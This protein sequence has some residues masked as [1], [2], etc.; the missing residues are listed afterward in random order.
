VRIDVSAEALAAGFSNEPAGTHTSRTVMLAELR[1][2]FG[3][4]PSDSG[5]RDYVAAIIDSNALKKRTRATRLKSLRHLRELY[6]L[7]ASV[8]LFGA[9]RALW[10]SDDDSQPLLAF[11]CAL[12]RDPLLRATA[13]LM[14]AS[15]EGAVVS[16]AD[17]SDEVGRSFPHRFST[18]VL[19]RIGRNVASSWT[20]SGHLEGRSTKVRTRV[21]ATAYSMTYAL[22]L[23]HLTQHS[24]TGLFR[25][26][27]VRLLEVPE[28][29]A[30][31]LARAASRQGWIGYRSAAGM[32]EIT[33]REL[34]ASS[35][36]KRAVG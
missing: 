28:S 15:P 14:L 2:L 21:H 4:T 16:A 9:L 34:E 36:E 25:T 5:Y 35:S 1:A 12:E 6:A 29:E 31:E 23:G 11:L 8:S 20:Q 22:F 18:G 13:N 32:T 26:L 19:G 33:F 24:G 10:D 3:T 27:E 30:R 17:F 7:D